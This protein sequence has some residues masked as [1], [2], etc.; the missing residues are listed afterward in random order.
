MMSLM[1][2]G[3]RT[4]WSI[5]GPRG[6]ID[7]I[8]PR[9][10]SRTQFVRFAIDL[11]TWNPPRAAEPSVEIRHGL[12][13]LERLRQRSGGLPSEFHLDRLRGARRPYLG[14]Y[15]GQIGHVSWLFTPVDRPR[16]ITLGPDEVEL[17]GAFTL[18]AAR[19]RRLLTAVECAILLDA[20]REGYARAYTHVAIDNV[21][22]LRGVAKTGFSPAGL[23]TLRWTLG[24]PWISYI[25]EHM[26]GLPV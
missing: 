17:D 25:A 4:V 20:R 24:L 12:D 16:L 23:V 3:L 15:D 18:P 19:G 1:P 7:A 2:D 5:G 22:S 14:F 6:L 13:E 8:R 10:V 9:L 11:E 26:V 21:A